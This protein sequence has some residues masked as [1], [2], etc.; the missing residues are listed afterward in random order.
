M[1]RM[2]MAT[3]LLGLLVAPATGEAQ[4]SKTE[5]DIARLELGALPGDFVAGLTG[6]GPPGQWSVVKDASAGPG[7]AIAQTSADRTDYRFPL[8]IY[9]KL[10]A[11]DVAVTIR[12]KPVA[13]RVDQSGG[14]AI[15]LTS[16]NDYYVV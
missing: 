2:A 16:P 8:A 10:D 6:Q 12:F 9:Q 1:R 14:I 7:R 4:M 13:G 15:R 5:I 11:K 3:V